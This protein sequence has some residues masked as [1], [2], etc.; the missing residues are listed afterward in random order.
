M[1]RPFLA[2]VLAA[3]VATP[4]AAAELNVGAAT[5]LA[6]AF[7]E[8]AHVYKTRHPGDEINLQFAPSGLLLQQYQTGAAFD[9]LALNDESTMN[10]AENAGLIRNGTRQRF[11]SNKLMLVMPYKSQLPIR[12]VLDLGRSAVKRVA[13]ENSATTSAGR[14]SRL[15]LMQAGIW[16]TV[17][18]KAVWGQNAHECL[19]LVARGEADAGF[20][21]ASE[22]LRRADEVKAV[23]EVPTQEPLSYALASTARVHLHRLA[24]RFADF[25]HGP[26]GQSILERYGFTPAVAANAAQ[27]TH[28]KL[29]QSNRKGGGNGG[30]SLKGK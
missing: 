18:A 14:Y 10:D 19:E 22:A 12:G 28:E 11:A 16:K 24:G 9:L 2:A 29:P 3:A 27:P 30:G 15:A 5:V 7:T 21:L 17:E 25:V 20:A 1:P 23:A 8:L 6:S 26:E 13:L 4:V